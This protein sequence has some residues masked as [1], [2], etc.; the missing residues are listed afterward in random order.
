MNYELYQTKILKSNMVQK[1]EQTDNLDWDRHSTVDFRIW[2]CCLL[3]QSYPE[4]HTESVTLLI[5][6]ADADCLHPKPGYVEI[7]IP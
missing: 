5:Q 7:P 3:K 6:K 1:E 2:L 4:T